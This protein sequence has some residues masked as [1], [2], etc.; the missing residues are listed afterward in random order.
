MGAAS[1]A[2]AFFVEVA[3]LSGVTAL[4]FELGS[5]GPERWLFAI[6]SGAAFIWI[7][8]WLAAPKSPRRLSGTFLFLLK[9]S[10]FALGT[11]GIASSQGIGI[12][13]AFGV[14]ATVH[15][16]SAVVFGRL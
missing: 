1:D 5:A 6:V 10:M 15:L 11:V 8:A 2:L 4:G 14:L 16:V 9:A 3:A 13:S 12:A 7:W